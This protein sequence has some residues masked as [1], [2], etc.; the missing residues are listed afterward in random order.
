VHTS[1]VSNKITSQQKCPPWEYLYLYEFLLTRVS[2]SDSDGV[3]AILMNKS[4]VSFYS[5]VVV[6]IAIVLEIIEIA[7]RK[8]DFEGETKGFV[9]LG[10]LMKPQLPS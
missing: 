5:Y 4:I 10:I 3:E 2:Q 8:C 1:S 7:I 9:R 6:N